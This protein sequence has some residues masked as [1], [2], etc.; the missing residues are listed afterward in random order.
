MIVGFTVGSNDD[1]TVAGWFAN[2][3]NALET[4]VTTNGWEIDGQ[5]SQLVQ[6]MATYF[7]QN[8]EFNSR[9]SATQV[10]TDSGLQAAIAVAWH[11]QA[12]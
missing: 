3:S 11:Q 5:V 9:T 2:Q 6:A 7:A 4:I 8:T 12:A 10:P 1:V